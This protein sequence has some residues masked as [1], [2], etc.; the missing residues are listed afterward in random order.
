MRIRGLVDED[1]INYKIPSMFIIFPHCDWKCEKEAGCA[2]CQNSAL[3]TSPTIEISAE[4]IIKRY[5]NDPITRV[6]VCGGLEPMDSFD[7]VVELIFTLRKNGCKD[8]VIIYTGYRK[9]EIIDKIEK[10][11]LFG[12]IIMKYGRFVPNQM[13]HYDKI[14][15]VKLA[16]DEQYGE[17]IC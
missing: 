2:M 17:R 6:L 9:R 15:G 4:E 14:L 10:L 12:N 11:S 8:D 3:A 16:N 13:P 7:D 1:F 5:L